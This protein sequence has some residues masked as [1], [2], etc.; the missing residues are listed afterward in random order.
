MMKDRNNILKIVPDHLDKEQIL[1]WVIN[2]FYDIE[3]VED[4]HV[5]LEHG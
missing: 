3:D 2:N 5:L 1:P 4:R